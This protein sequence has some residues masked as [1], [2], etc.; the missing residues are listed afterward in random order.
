MFQLCKIKWNEGLVFRVNMSQKVLKEIKLKNM[1]KLYK[2]RQL[3]L[4]KKWKLKINKG[5]IFIMSNL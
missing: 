1:V 3:F 5:I 4:C 2:F